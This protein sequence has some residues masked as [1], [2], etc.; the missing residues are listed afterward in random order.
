MSGVKYLLDTNVIIG[1]FN[2]T[3]DA[4][5]MLAARN[6]RSN[7]CGYSAITRME[8]LGYPGITGEE[9]TAIRRLLSRLSYLPLTRDIE[10]T[11]IPVRRARRVKLPDAIIAATAKVHGLELLT[12]DKELEAIG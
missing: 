11:A 12:L 9:E 3:Q 6:L 8:L 4:L 10:D 7:E 1:L 5:Q 2:R